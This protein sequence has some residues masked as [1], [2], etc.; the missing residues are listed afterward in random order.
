MELCETGVSAPPRFVTAVLATLG[1]V[2]AELGMFSEASRELHSALQIAETLPAGDERRARVHESLGV[3]SLRQGLRSQAERHL[4]QSIEILQTAFGSSNSEV[5]AVELTLAGVLLQDNRASEAAAL[6]R[7]ARGKLVATLGA[8]HPD[9]IFASV[10]FG[11]AL[12]ESAPLEAERLLRE[13]LAAWLARLPEKHLAVMSIWSALG[14]AQQAL[15]RTREAVASSAKALEIA[16][17]VTGQDSEQTMR[18][19][20]RYA[21]S[22][23]AAK[24]KKDST[25]M[26][27]AAERIRSSKG[28]SDPGR[29]SIDFQALRRRR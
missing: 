20:Y 3:L 9:S 7:E 5:A 18:S 8:A 10:L 14:D 1:Q 24:R 29:Y 15:G 19:M 21:D 13:A 28:Y 22:L 25:A 11:A 12:A 4:R 17:A 6:A 27:A 23:K 2:H 16:H 26:L